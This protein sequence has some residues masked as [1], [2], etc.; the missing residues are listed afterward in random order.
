MEVQVDPSGEVWIW[1]AVAYAVSQ[2]SV[3]WQ[4]DW[5]EPRSTSSHCGS[6]NALDQRVPRLPSTAA[7]A[8]KLAFSSDDAV[9]GRFSA[10]FV[11]PQAAADVTAPWLGAV[12]ARNAATRVN[13]AMTAPKER[14]RKR[15]RASACGMGLMAVLSRMC[16]TRAGAGRGPSVN[17]TGSAGG[18]RAA[19]AMDRMEILAMPSAD[20]W[21]AAAQRT[22]GRYLSRRGRFRWG[23]GRGGTAD[24]GALPLGR[25][26]LSLASGQRRQASQNLRRDARHLP[27]RVDRG[28]EVLPAHP[29][30]LGQG[31]GR[32]R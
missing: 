17:G 7:E 14:W 15:R 2:F 10:R 16:G 21:N 32:D 23:R 11:V 5:V 3:T 1:N 29:N 28:S 9:A 13:A 30:P 8:G 20:V 19:L 22:S 12:V 25:R 4:I 6:E 18:R 26:T 27:G 24:G 31:L